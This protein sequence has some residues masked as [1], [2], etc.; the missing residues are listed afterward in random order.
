MI[1]LF[2]A[3]TGAQNSLIDVNIYYAIPD[4]GGNDTFHTGKTATL[5]YSYYPLSWLAMSAGIFFSEEIFD[6]TKTDI[7]GSYQSSIQTRGMTI[8]IR[9]E[10]RLS[11]RNKIYF[12]GGFLLYDTRLTV[13]EFFEPGRPSGKSSASTQGNGYYLAFG[14]SHYFTDTVSFQLELASLSQ[15]RLF[16][17]QTRS[18][19]VFD[20]SFRG[21]SIGLAYGF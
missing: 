17:D 4:A 13:S 19:N 10:Y 20:L 5:N 6:Q 9:P 8:G 18:D 3:N 12:R 2:S 15:Q 21:F 14:W 11:K 16:A 1:F 7:V